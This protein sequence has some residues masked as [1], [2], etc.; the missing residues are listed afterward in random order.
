METAGILLASDILKESIDHA[1]MQEEM[2]PPIILPLA[3]E[4]NEGKIIVHF[5]H[6][7]RLEKLGNQVVF[8]GF[9]EPSDDTPEQTR[10]FILH[11]PDTHI[12]IIQLFESDIDRGTLLNIP[13][14]RIAREDSES[15]G[16]FPEKTSQ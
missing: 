8:F 7:E 4:G 16:F 14:A 15:F 1:K 5:F 2:V 11:T 6:Y 13:I 9:V 3:S 10:E 12:P